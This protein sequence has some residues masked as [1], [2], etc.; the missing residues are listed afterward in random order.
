MFFLFT[1]ETDN[2]HPAKQ[3]RPAR[4]EPTEPTRVTTTVIVAFALQMI[5]STAGVL[6]GAMMLNGRRPSDHRLPTHPF[7]AVM[8]KDETGVSELLRE[9]PEADGRGVRVAVLDTG[10]DVAAAG[11]QTT[12][13]GKPKYIDIIDCTGSG[14]IEMKKHA[15]MSEDGSI[16]GAS[17]RKLFLGDWASDAADADFRIGAVRLYSLLP[18]SARAR[19]LRERRRI[20][21]V[22]QHAAIAEAQ[23]ELDQLEGAPEKPSPGVAD[24]ASDGASDGAAPKSAAP[25]SAAERIAAKKELKERMSELRSMLEKYEDVGPLMDCVMYKDTDGVW[26][27]AVD[28]ECNGDLKNVKPLAPYA[29]EREHGVL[30]LG[31]AVSFCVQVYESGNILSLVVDAGSHG[32]HVAGI[33]GA[34]FPSEPHLNGVAPGAQILALKIGDSRLGSAETG[35]GLVRAL[36]A[37]KR[38]GCH[39]LNLSY[40]ETYWQADYGAVAAVFDAAVHKWGICGLT[41]AGNDGPALSTLGSPGC[42]SSLICI[43][44]HASPAMRDAQYS[45]LPPDDEDAPPPVASAYYFSSRGPTPDG[46]VPAI[47]APGGAIAPVPRHTLQGKQHM[48]GTSMA[49]PSATG[50]AACVLSALLQQGVSPTPAALRRAL[51]AGA[52]EWRATEPNPIDEAESAL[53]QG[54]GLVR[55]PEAL[56][57]ALTHHEK[58]ANGLSF[59][60]RLPS[61]GGARGLYLRDLAELEQGPRAFAVEVRPRWEHSAA[62]SEQEVAGKRPPPPPPTPPRISR[63]RAASLSRLERAMG[64][65]PGLTH[66]P[67]G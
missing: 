43:G 2:R 57:Y 55:A 20:F 23:R 18:G 13:D 39:V 36:I 46:H 53:S 11:L 47:A 38:Y 14:D 33:I 64:G 17:G 66:A 37:A 51:E 59:D 62:M 25:K 31:S 6:S 61:R 63:F 5:V 16:E 65:R 9:Q 1:L 7:M 8:P 30:G 67:L 40:G 48:H 22:E 52:R 27:A 32:T 4:S 58:V 12:T 3:S 28:V 41:S 19:V 29:I 50:V 24:G 26:R 45:A 60:V 49:S 15:K 21:E 44:A 10:C 56:S 34:H 42:L 54:H 35:V